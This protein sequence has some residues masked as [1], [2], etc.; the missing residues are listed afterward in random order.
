MKK[1]RHTTCWATS[2]TSGKKPLLTESVTG[3]TYG[4][5]IRGKHC[6]ISYRGTLEWMF[7]S[8]ILKDGE[9]MNTSGLLRYSQRDHPFQGSKCLDFNVHSTTKGEP[10][11]TIHPLPGNGD[12][13]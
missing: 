1:C 9:V 13:D 4:G 2:M 12:I 6:R 11:L 8:R 7:N 10:Y 5:K 3:K